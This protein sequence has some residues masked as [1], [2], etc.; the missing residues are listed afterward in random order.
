MKWLGQQKQKRRAFTAHYYFV[1]AFLLEFTVCS[2]VVLL[3]PGSVELQ[4]QRLI[5][6]LSER[7]TLLLVVVVGMDARTNSNWMTAVQR[8]Y[9]KQLSASAVCFPE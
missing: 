7:V 3:S 8:N 6:Q 9:K 4:Q 5:I 1:A 2:C